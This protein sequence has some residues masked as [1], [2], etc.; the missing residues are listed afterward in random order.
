M[1]CV[2]IYIYIG[3]A[4]ERGW[5]EM[6]RDTAERERREGAKR[7]P[8]MNHDTEADLGAQKSLLWVH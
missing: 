6:E 7:L 8:S 1:E 5:T 3:C 2:Y 4:E